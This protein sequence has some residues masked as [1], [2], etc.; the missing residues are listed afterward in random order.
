MLPNPR[1]TYHHSY[2]LLGMDF[3]SDLIS[4]VTT[5][6]S[7]CIVLRKKGGNI[8]HRYTQ[9]FDRLIDC[10]CSLHLYLQVFHH[11]ELVNRYITYVSQMTT[12]CYFTFMANQLIFKP[13]NMA[14]V[15]TEPEFAYMSEAPGFILGLLRRFWRYQKSNHNP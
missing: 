4:A 12:I 7:S 10:W 8:V 2:V 1:W 3:S 15:A 6:L 14:S 13:D 5:V 9:I 11:H